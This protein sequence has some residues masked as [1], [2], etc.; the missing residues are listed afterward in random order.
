M[1]LRNNEDIFTQLIETIPNRKKLEALCKYMWMFMHLL[2]VR[3]LH[4]DSDKEKIHLLTVQ[5]AF[6]EIK[7]TTP[8][9]FYIEDNGR[10]QDIFTRHIILNARAWNSQPPR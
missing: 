1:L 5:Y 7:G 6:E 2:R 4:D 10:Y 8:I 3:S 9:I